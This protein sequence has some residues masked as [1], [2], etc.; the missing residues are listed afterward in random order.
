MNSTTGSYSELFKK[1]TAH[2]PQEQYKDRV[3]A[4]M[5]GMTYEEYI[6]YFS[7]LDKTI[8]NPFIRLIKTGDAK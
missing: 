7:L 6:E 3:C 5:A 8:N 2:W 4:M 1:L